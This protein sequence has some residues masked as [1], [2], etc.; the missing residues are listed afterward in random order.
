MKRFNLPLLFPN[1]LSSIREDLKNDSIVWEEKESC[2][3][4]ADGNMSWLTR[5]VLPKEV[6][7]EATE[8]VVLWFN[9]REGNAELIWVSEW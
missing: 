5:I 6:S 1:T 8:P 7:E 3:V 9:G 2:D 4:D